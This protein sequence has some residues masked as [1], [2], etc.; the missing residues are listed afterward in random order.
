MPSNRAPSIGICGWIVVVGWAVAFVMVMG[1]IVDRAR[2]KTEVFQ[3][4]GLGGKVFSSGQDTLAET[5]RKKGAKVR[6]IYQFYEWQQVVEDIK[7]V[8]AGRRIVVVGNSNGGNAATWVQAATKRKIHYLQVQDPTIWL[9][10]SPIGKHVSRADCVWNVNPFSALIP[11]GHRR[12]ELVP[13]YP[14]KRFKEI[15]TWAAHTYVDKDPTNHARVV[16]Q[17]A[18]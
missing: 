18:N 6:P 8:P 17:V 2:A 3:L 7:K 10:M 9:P 15:K 12:C 1:G 13:G 11:V 4:Y 16:E 14:Q 5:L